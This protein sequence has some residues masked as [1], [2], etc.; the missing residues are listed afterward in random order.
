MDTG[1]RHMWRIDT[2]LPRRAGDKLRV[3]V[4]TS[5]EPLPGTVFTYPCGCYL[6]IRN[7][8]G[9]AP[10]LYVQPSMETWTTM[11]EAPVAFQSNV[12]LGPNINEEMSNDLERR[13]HI[14]ASTTLTNHP[15]PT[16]DHIQ[17]VAAHQVGSHRCISDGY[18]LICLLRTRWS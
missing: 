14:A 1:A 18:S 17:L 8:Q 6:L 12:A 5:V 10:V 3:R 11:P 7:T 15:Q 16:T 13:S 9:I 4:H 2:I